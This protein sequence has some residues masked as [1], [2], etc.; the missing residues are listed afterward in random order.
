MKISIAHF[1]LRNSYE[2]DHTQS[3]FMMLKVVHRPIRLR[4]RRAPIFGLSS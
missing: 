1:V 4:M 3:R 2:K